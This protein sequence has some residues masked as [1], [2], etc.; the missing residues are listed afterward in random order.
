N[1]NP[2]D[3]ELLS[4]VSVPGGVSTRWNK[5]SSTIQ[6][7]SLAVRSRHGHI[8]RTHT[9]THQEQVNHTDED[10]SPSV[11]LKRLVT[12]SRDRVSLGAC[13]RSPMWTRSSARVKVMR[14]LGWMPHTTIQRR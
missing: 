4:S 1:S 8:T 7:I 6:L 13:N 2:T 5:S 12:K 9:H 11:A 14:T 3:T 10:R